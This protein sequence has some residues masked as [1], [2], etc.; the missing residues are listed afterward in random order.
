ME[1]L[2]KAALRPRHWKQLARS[3]GASSVLT[4]EALSRMSLNQFLTLGLQLYSDEVRNIVKR[5]AKDVHIEN[6]LKSYEEIWLSKVFDTKQHT[7]LSANHGF[8]VNETASVSV[9]F[10]IFTEITISN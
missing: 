8:C 3:T 4:N 5:S 2:G 10:L 7:R 1:D 6:L 9:S